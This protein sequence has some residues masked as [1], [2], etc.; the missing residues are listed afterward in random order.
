MNIYSKDSKHT[1]NICKGLKGEE[2]RLEWGVRAAFHSH[3]VETVS[4]KGSLLVHKNSGQT[5]VPQK[6]AAQVWKVPK[7]S[8]Q[9]KKIKS[10][11][12]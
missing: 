3:G 4:R 5:P 1:K 11:I 6:L 10:L 8:F 2:K 9:M 12:A 7:I